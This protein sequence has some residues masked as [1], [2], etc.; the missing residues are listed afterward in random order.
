MSLDVV[1]GTDSEGAEVMVDIARAPHMLVAGMTGSGKSVFMNALIYELITRYTP[2]QVRLLFIDPK[3]VEFAQYA[4]CHHAL[5]R[6]AVMFT[7]AMEVLHWTQQQMDERFAELGKLGLRS[8]DSMAP[9]DRWP[10]IVLVIDEMANLILT[11]KR[12]VEKRL[13]DITAM[14]RAVGIHVILATQR[15]SADIVTGIIRANVPMRVAFAVV[16][17]T[18]SR[19]ILDEDGADTITERGQ[20]LVR[21]PGQRQ[22]ERLQGKY[23]SEADIAAAVIRTRRHP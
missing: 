20:F 8:I 18:E 2:R 4:D 19:I 22:L 12:A 15:P 13:A 6:P 16:T 11:D 7:E 21:I 17:R 5:A 23:I 3:R 1:I 14:S 10:Y 9:E